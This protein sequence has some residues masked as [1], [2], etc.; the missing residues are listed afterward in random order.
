MHQADAEVGSLRGEEGVQTRRPQRTG[1]APWKD[2]W[3]ANFRGRSGAGQGPLSSSIPQRNP[4]EGGGGTGADPRAASFRTASK[5][6]ERPPRWLVRAFLSEGECGDVAGGVRLDY[7]TGV[8]LSTEERREVLVRIRRGGTA[9]LRRSGGN[10]GG[11]EY[12][13][14]I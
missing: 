9:L 4:R 13:C 8:L 14:P 3:R 7:G 6:V 5:T 1:G 10:A 12:R 2:E 11:G